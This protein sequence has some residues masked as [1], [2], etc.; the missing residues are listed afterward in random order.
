M[1]NP[2]DPEEPDDYDSY[3][4]LPA[5]ECNRIIIDY[6][7]CGPEIEDLYLTDQTLSDIEYYDAMGRQLAD[8]PQ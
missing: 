1:I 6:F 4:F 8:D 5:G 7:S 2:E 3:Y